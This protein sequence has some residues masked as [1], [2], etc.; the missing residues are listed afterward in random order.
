MERQLNAA[1]GFLALDSPHFTASPWCHRETELAILREVQLQRDRPDASFIRVL[2]LADTPHRDIGFLDAY[3]KY[4]VSDP[5]RRADELRKL[6]A[7][8]GPA[9]SS[10]TA[11]QHRQEPAE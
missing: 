4:D 5:G 6:R 10:K 1:N 2:K 9:L 3:D 11:A 7:N 8:L